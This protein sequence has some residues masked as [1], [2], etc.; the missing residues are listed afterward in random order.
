[1]D[2]VRNSAL[3]WLESNGRVEMKTLSTEQE[4]EYQNAK[5]CW[6]C[7]EGKYVKNKFSFISNF[8]TR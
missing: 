1:M 8:C 2:T 3:D 7:G 5:T 6:L 4:Q